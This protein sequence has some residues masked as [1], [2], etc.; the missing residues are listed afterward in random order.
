M[1]LSNMFQSL[2]PVELNAELCAM[3][4]LHLTVGRLFKV[5]DLKLYPWSLITG[6]DKYCGADALVHLYIRTQTL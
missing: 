2:G 5:V 4:V 6:S 1:S 3:A